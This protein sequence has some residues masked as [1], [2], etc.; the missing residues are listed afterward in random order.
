[1]VTD[2]DAAAELAAMKAMLDEA[3]SIYDA[4]EHGPLELIA[5]YPGRG[6]ERHEV[7]IN[8]HPDLDWR[9]I[10]LDPDGSAT[11]VGRL[12]GADDLRSQAVACAED[13]ATQCRLFHA[14]QRADPP[15]L[16]PKQMQMTV[17]PT[18]HRQ[19]PTIREGRCRS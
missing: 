7:C 15:I 10:D 13:Y 5:T 1:V 4:G 18:G 17:P 14:S 16:R 9:V 8:P 6:G 3:A 11:L 12:D 2:T 19:E